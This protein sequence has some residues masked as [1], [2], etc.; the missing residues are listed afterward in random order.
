MKITF[1]V[2]CITISDADIDNIFTSKRIF[3]SKNNYKYFIGYINDYKIKLFSIILPKT[4]AYVKTFDGETK[5][6]YF[7]IE[8]EELLK[9]YIMIFG[10]KSAIV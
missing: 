6:I 7:M 8:D 5:S 1:F 2:K 10:I 3:S 4:S 9:E